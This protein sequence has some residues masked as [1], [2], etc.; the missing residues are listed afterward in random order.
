MKSFRA[1]GCVER[2]RCDVN[3]SCEGQGACELMCGGPQCS[4]R[5]VHS[6]TLF[7]HHRR[8]AA[9]FALCSAAAGLL[10]CDGG[11]Q[12]GSYYGVPQYGFLPDKTSSEEA[13]DC[14]KH[15]LPHPDSSYGRFQ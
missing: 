2:L 4:H 3:N 12:D 10:G 14:N 9:M 15:L 11:W 6:W 1:S 8:D 5:G 7:S 13:L